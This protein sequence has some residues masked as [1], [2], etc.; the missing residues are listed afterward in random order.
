VLREG[1][2]GVAEVNFY[3]AHERQLTDRR[4]GEERMRIGGR[5]IP[6]L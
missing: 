3:G 6:P 1:P 5:W 2:G 4:T